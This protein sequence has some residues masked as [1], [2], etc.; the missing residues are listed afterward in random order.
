MI[1]ALFW[2]AY[3]ARGTS[4]Y[5]PITRSLFAAELS[6]CLGKMV[7]VNSMVSHDLIKNALFTPRLA[8]Y[9]RDLHWHWINRTLL[10]DTMEVSVLRWAWL[11]ITQHVFQLAR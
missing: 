7:D 1:A 9:S 8:I 10:C 3:T 11:A 6:Q 4:E 5:L 2:C